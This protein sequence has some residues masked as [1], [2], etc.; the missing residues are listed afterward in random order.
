MLNQYEI[1][2]NTPVCVNPV[3]VHPQE[4]RMKLAAEFDEMDEAALQAMH[5]VV[6]VCRRRGVTSSICGQAPSFYPELVEMLVDWGITSISINPDTVDRTRRM[7]AA[8]EA[9]LLLESALERQD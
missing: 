3:S 7:I 5:A 8:S 9:R 4:R 2:K 6:D 1:I